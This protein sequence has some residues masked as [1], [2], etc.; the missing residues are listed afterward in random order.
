MS[1][2]LLDLLWF[3]STGIT[4]AK[5]VLYKEDNPVIQVGRGNPRIA[6]VTLGPGNEGRWALNRKQN[7][8]TLNRKQNSDTLNRKQNFDCLT[9]LVPLFEDLRGPIV[10]ITTLDDEAGEVSG[11]TD[12]APPSSAQSMSRPTRPSHIPP[13]RLS[14]RTH[15][16]A[17]FIQNLFMQ[18]RIYY[19]LIESMRRVLLG[20]MG[21]AYKNTW[22]STIP[23]IILLCITSLQLFFLVLEK[24]FIKRRVQL[25]EIISVASE[26]CLFA[27]FLVL[28]GKELSPKQ[29]TIVGVSMLVLFLMG[30]LPQIV[31]E[32]YA[33]RR[34]IK[35]LDTA[36]KRFRTGLRIA[37]FGILLFFISQ[38]SLENPDCFGDNGP[39]DIGGQGGEETTND[40]GGQGGE[41]SN[42]DTGGQGDEDTN[43]TKRNRNSGRGN[44]NPKN[45]NRNRNSETTV[46]EKSWLNQ[47][48]K[49]VT[50]CL[51]IA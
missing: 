10:S 31:N 33:L 51:G 32:L 27:L 18:L 43:A 29:E 46:P 49:A 5:R 19:T 20:A 4:F 47:L 13:T 17:S 2:L 35:H 34:Q 50:N 42:K 1:F 28:V 37:S 44:K 39:N 7:S 22:S 15:A 48:V 6:Q 21:G 11:G 3:L 12:F 41:E 23:V 16:E 45:R 8:D 14:V 9:M 24:P 40:T 38:D 36:K 25:V 30:F 26:V